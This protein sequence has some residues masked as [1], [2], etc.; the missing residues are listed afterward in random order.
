MWSHGDSLVGKV[1]PYEHEILSDFSSENLRKLK[2]GYSPLQSHHWEG[3]KSKMSRA[4]WSSGFAQPI[5]KSRLVATLSQKTKWTSGHHS[6][7][8]WLQAATWLGMCFYMYIHEHTDKHTHTDTQQKFKY[9]L[10][11]AYC[12]AIFNF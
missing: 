5:S 3:R 7:W 11:F 12:I 4:R 8:G 1:L 9:I 2:Q 10:C 6:C